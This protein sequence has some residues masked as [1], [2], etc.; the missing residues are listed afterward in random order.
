MITVTRTSEPE[1]K[2]FLFTIERD[3]QTSL[4]LTRAEAIARLTLFEVDDAVRLVDQAAVYGHVII[5]EHG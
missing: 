5:H 2:S 1:A 4:R 3:G